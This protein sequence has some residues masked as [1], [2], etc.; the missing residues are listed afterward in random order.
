LSSGLGFIVA[1]LL[2]LLSISPVPDPISG[3]GRPSTSLGTAWI[4]G[5]V[6]SSSRHVLQIHYLFASHFCVQRPRSIHGSRGYSPIP[7]LLVRFPLSCWVHAL[8]S[9]LRTNGWLCPAF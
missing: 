6:F 7:I 9:I 5:G 8:R 4:I 2:P 3:V 1:S